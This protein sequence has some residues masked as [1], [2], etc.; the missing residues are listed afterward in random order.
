MEQGKK[1]DKKKTRY[2]LLPPYAIEQMAK[3]MTL[4]ADKYGDRNWEAGIHFTR[5]I[6]ACERHLAAISRGEDYDPESGLLHSAHLLCEAGFLTEYYKI[7][8]EFDDRPKPYMKR[9]GLDIDDVLADFMGAY[10]NR[11]GTEKPKAWNFD[12]YFEE[13]YNEVCEDYNFWKTMKPMY[14]PGILPFEP[15]CYITNRGCPKE[16]TEEWLYSNRF[17]SAPVHYVGLEGSK[18]D[19]AKQ[20]NLDIFVDDCFKNFVELNQAGVFTR[21]LTASHNLRYNVGHYRLDSLYDI[22][23]KITE[24]A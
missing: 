5:I 17:P 13:R 8:P 6:G 10:S 2:E 18:V 4:G 22:F 11:F 20:E 21:L 9:V 23:G 14:F 19:I 16:W 3:V 7:R 24:E 12:P 1:F 15:V